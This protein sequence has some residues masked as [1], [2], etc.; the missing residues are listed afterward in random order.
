MLCENLEAATGY[1]RSHS[2]ACVTMDGDKIAK[3]GAIKGGYYDTS[4]SKIKLN[5]A[6][7]S[8]EEKLRSK[9]KEKAELETKRKQL[10]QSNTALLG[11]QSKLR[12]EIRSLQV[13]LQSSCSE[14]GA[15]RLKVQI[16]S[17]C[18]SRFPCVTTCMR[19]SVAWH[20]HGDDPPVRAKSWALASDLARKSANNLKLCR[21]L[22]RVKAV[23]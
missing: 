10:D 6:V 8:E 1:R 11:E 21:R 3:K 7:R 20:F 9:E 16:C 14:D 2:I 13:C 23:S 22:Y 4:S 5:K 12:V 19:T 17:M 18:A 15:A